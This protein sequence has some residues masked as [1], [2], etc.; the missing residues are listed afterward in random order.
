[1]RKQF[2]N[3]LKVYVV[4]GGNKGKS[5]LVLAENSERAI[6]TA[7]IHEVGTP[8]VKIVDSTPTIREYM[9]FDNKPMGD[10]EWYDEFLNEWVINVVVDHT[11]YENDEADLLSDGMYE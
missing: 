4:V 1:M 9:S 2:L 10:I 7:D 6:E 5:E 11:L 8:S 3:S